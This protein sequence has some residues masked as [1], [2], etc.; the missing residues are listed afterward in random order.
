VGGGAAGRECPGRI[1]SADRAPRG[2]G[3]GPWPRSEAVRMGPGRRPLAPKRAVRA[4]R[5]S[6]GIPDRTGGCCSGQASARGAVSVEYTWSAQP[7][8]CL[9]VDPRP[10]PFPCH[11]TSFPLTSLPRLVLGLARPISRSPSLA[12]LSRLRSC[13]RAQA[14][15]DMCNRFCTIFEDHHHP[16]PARHRPSSRSPISPRWKREGER[17]RGAQGADLL[18]KSSG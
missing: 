2:R 1:G 14:R 11:R 10:I 12:A 8:R 7:L 3:R 15:E 17:E 13:V 16:H 5:A 4:G 6:G 9:R 18:W